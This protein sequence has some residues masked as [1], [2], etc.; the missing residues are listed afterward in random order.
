MGIFGYSECI[1]VYKNKSYSSCKKEF[2]N[3]SEYK[4]SD[5]KCTLLLTINTEVFSRHMLCNGLPSCLTLGS[6]AVKTH[7]LNIP[8]LLFVHKFLKIEYVILVLLLFS[9]QRKCF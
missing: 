7:T 3:E 1:S 5:W 8:R 6:S 4:E 9:R 2:A